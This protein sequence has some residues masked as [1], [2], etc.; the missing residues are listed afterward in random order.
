MARYIQKARQGRTVKAILQAIRMQILTEKQRHVM[1]QAIIILLMLLS[2][3]QQKRVCIRELTTK[4][5]RIG[6]GCILSSVP[7]SVLLNK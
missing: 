7:L 6:T 3:D 1:D 2:S 4:R 5:V